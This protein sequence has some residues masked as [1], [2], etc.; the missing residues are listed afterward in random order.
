MGETELETQFVKSKVG[1]LR[2]MIVIWGLIV[3]VMVA[4]SPNCTG[5]LIWV[6]LAFLVSMCLSLCTYV[7]QAKSLTPKIPLKIPYQV[8]FFHMS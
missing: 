6:V 1:I 5:A 4:A 2:I 3:F 7:I 8:R